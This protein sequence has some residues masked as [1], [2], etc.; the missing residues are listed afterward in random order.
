MY[1][2][3]INRILEDI[4]DKFNFKILFFFATV[5]LGV[6]ITLGTNEHAH[7][8]KIDFDIYK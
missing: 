8:F 7:V 5:F 2:S 1:Y 4:V 6:F 3:K